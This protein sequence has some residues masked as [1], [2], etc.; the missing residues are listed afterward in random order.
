MAV[1][2]LHNQIDK[3][4]ALNVQAISTNTTTDGN[5]I[6]TQGFKSVEFLYFT[7]AY[8]DGS[9]SLLIT[10]GDASNLSDGTSTGNS[11]VLTET[12]LAITAANTVKK[13]GYIGTKRYLRFRCVST[14][15][16]SGATLGA[17]CV[18]SDPDSSPVA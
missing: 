11:D 10:E 13:I 17:I 16:T 18:L 8:T 3:R 1:K 12:T 15:V 6:D 14:S 7:G 5:I 9:Y 4:I 2:D